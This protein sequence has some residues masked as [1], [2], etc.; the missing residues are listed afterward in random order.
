[1]PNNIKPN[2]F[3]ASREYPYHLSVGAVVVNDDNQ[4]FCHYFNELDIHGIIVKDLYLLMRESLELNESLEQC[5]S[6]GLQEEYGV[7]GEIISF[8]GT[9]VTQHND[10]GFL[11]HKS[12]LYFLVKCTEFNIENRSKNDHESGSILKFYDK[13]FLIKKMYGQGR[14]LNRTDLDESEILKLL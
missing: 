14:D 3:R 4:I 1:M 13:D 2:I 10:T 5:L 11:V 12:T 9:L 6:R 8:L 7:K